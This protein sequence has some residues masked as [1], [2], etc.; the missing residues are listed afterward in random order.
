MFMNYNLTLTSLS[1]MHRACYYLWH[2]IQGSKGTNQIA[3]ALLELVI[4][5][6]KV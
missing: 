6:N 2:E 4:R 5:E 1:G 3:F